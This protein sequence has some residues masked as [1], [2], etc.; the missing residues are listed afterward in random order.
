LFLP[1]IKEVGLDRYKLWDDSQFETFGQSRLQSFR[2][3]KILRRA[4]L[5]YLIFLEAISSAGA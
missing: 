5:L 4:R 3:A 2:G 1:P